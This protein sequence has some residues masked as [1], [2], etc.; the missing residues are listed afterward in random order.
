MFSNTKCECGHQN[1]VGTVLCESCG[2][3]LTETGAD[4][5]APLEMRY[6]G[7]ARRSQKENPDLIDRVWN[8]FSSVKIAVWLIVLTLVAASVGTLYPQENVFRETLTYEEL[9]QYYRENYGKA[10]EVYHALGLTHVY[11]SWWFVTLL[12]MIGTSLVICSLDRVLPLYRALSKQQIRKHLQF[13]TRQQ[14]VYAGPA[15]EDRDAWLERFG[16]QLKKRRYK[17]W[18]DGDALMAEKNRFSRWGPYIN[19]IG[20]IIFLLAVLGRGVPAWNMDQY[21]YLDDGETEQIPGTNYYV[22]NEK[23]TVEFYK[24]S[25]LPE[26]L[27]GTLRPKLFNTEATL[28]ECTESCDDPTKE[29]VLRAVE[30]HNIQVNH[31]LSYHGLKLYQTDYS[32]NQ[33]L[34]SVSPVIINKKT[35]EKY[36]PFYLPMRNPALTYDVGPYNLT[37]RDVFLDF[38]IDAQ[39]RPMTKSRDPNA[40]AFVFRI[41]GPDLPETGETYIYFPN[42]VDKVRFSQDQLNKSVADKLDIRVDSMENVSFSNYTTT[43]NVRVDRAMPFVWVGASIFMIGVI[44]GLYW[45]HRRIWLRFDDGILSLGAHTNKNNYGLRTEVAAALNKAGLSVSEKSLDNRRKTD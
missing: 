42:R 9:S 21:M 44:M 33:R 45:N 29:P 1:H 24:D 38:G 15:P 18:R 7:V 43:L 35:G 13:I 12:V 25:E 5:F 20:L 2:K 3:P 17:V 16:E 36:G 40:P 39:G 30:T 27:K 14:V 41:K 32:E 34:I 19:H 10:G 8:F 23:F 11:S 28:Y 4:D 22:K 26:S 37:L 6:D 31:P